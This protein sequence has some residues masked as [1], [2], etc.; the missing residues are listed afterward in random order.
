[1]IER[2]VG[3]ATI[4]TDDQLRL[5]FLESCD[6]A[7]RDANDAYRGLAP[8][9]V[10]AGVPAVLA[11]QDL[12]EVKTAR[13]FAATF[14]RQLLR[15]G[16][17]DLACNEARDAVRTQKL[18]GAE[19]PVLFMR[20]RSG[21]LL[22]VR[23]RVSQI[24]SPRFWSLLV[25]NLNRDR[26]V[27]FLG[28]RINSGIVPR[29]ESIARSL[30]D[31]NGYALADVDNLAR[32]A[33]F[34]GYRDPD[35]FR[36]MYMKQL[37]RSVYRSLGR[38]PTKEQL[39]RLDQRTLTEVTR[40]VDW[41]RSSKDVEDCQ[42][43][44][45]LADLQLPL[46]I[47]MNVDDF[48]FEALSSHAKLKPGDVRRLGPRWEKTT[49]GAPP[50]SVLHPEPSTTT[51]YVLHLNGFDDA[52]DRSQFDHVALSEDDLM[53]KYVRL[54]RDQVE[55][56]PSNIST[57][58][59]ESSWMFLGYNLDDWEF[60]IILQ[61]L[62]QPIAQA[63]AKT[64]LHIGVQLEPAAGATGMSEAEVQRYLQSYLEQRFNITV[65]WGSPAQFVAELHR[66]FF[67]G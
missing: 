60:R 26:C 39:D 58:L 7:K 55:I 2:Q 23:G 47:T 61:G 17:V 63:K 62:L 41:G 28:P 21:E 65:Y 5:V 22:R 13:P 31:D 43:Y 32:V 4:G 38:E 57:K 20:L 42:L 19:I 15:H 45:L 6:T 29:P 12:V 66:R 50:H 35:S 37:K 11:M 44:H 67:Q 53:A 46:Y 33:Q 16:Q 64:K 51:P 30:A 25:T 56:I 40:E 34:A 48:M 54:A 59:A 10:S 8:Q 27:P 14:Y 36:S 24:D 49:E 3:D 1:M 52:A 18:R 9:L